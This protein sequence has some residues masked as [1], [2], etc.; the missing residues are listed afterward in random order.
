MSSP[1]PFCSLGFY[2]NSA[3][4]NALKAQSECLIEFSLFIDGFCL[5]YG[6]EGHPHDADVAMTSAVASVW[7]GTQ[8]LFCLWHVNKNLV[9]KCAGALS[10]DDRTRMLRSFR[11][12]AY[13][14]NAEVRFEA[15]S[16]SPGMLFRSKLSDCLGSYLIQTWPNM[17]L[18]VATRHRCAYFQAFASSRGQME[19]ISAGTKCEEYVDNLFK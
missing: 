2:R 14:V 13:A 9:K 1:N 11:G 6:V 10:D 4:P 7:K 5:I 3:F 16:P 18:P 8:H 19:Q 12:A 17:A 15:S